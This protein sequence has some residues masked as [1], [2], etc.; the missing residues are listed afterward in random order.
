MTQW[1]PTRKVGAESQKTYPSKVASGFLDKYLSG[2]NIL[3]IG[4]RGSGDW[5]TD[6]GIVPNATGIDLGY[7]GYDGIHLPF[8]DASQDAVY[9]SHCLEH[10]TDYQSAL[11]EW[12]RVL[13][14]GGFLIVVVPHYQLYEKT[15]FLPS[16]FNGDHK[17]L[18]HPGILLAEIHDSLPIGE[19]RLR[20]CQENDLGFDYSLPVDVHSA[21]SYEIECVIEKIPHHQYIDQMVQ[22][23]Q[24][25]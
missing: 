21:G 17:R 13:K 15:F 2:D 8:P 18:Y 11:K 3:E 9:S 4:H 1:D 12:F 23:A 14:I 20:Y 7:P 6:L 16:R 10:I 24:N 25:R 22:L 5:E 19:W